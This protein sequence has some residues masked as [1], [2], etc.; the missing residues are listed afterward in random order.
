MKIKI[1]NKEY[2]V[3]IIDSNQGKV[4]IKIGDNWFDFFSKEH[5]EKLSSISSSKNIISEKE[6]K[7]P[8]SGTISEIF[9]KEG[10]E[11]KQGD[12]LL[13]LSAMK[14]ENEIVS[15]C[16]SKIKK[17]LIEKNQKV[18]EGDLLISLS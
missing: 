2:E 12:K 14:M 8:L 4:S 9:V 1:K 13:I 5:T 15:T 6:I 16:D 3:E 18:A 10:D 11:I 7:A 17:I